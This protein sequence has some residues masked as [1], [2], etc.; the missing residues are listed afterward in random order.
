M[1]APKRLIAASVPILAAALA[2][3]TGGTV[4]RFAPCASTDT[5]PQSTVCEAVATGVPTF[6]TWSCGG[7][8]S[9][10][11]C[12]ND[13]NGIQG[14]CVIAIGNDDTTIGSEDSF[15]FCLQ[16]CSSGGAC[17]DGETCQPAQDY[18]GGSESDMV[19]VPSQ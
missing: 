8:T 2:C 18:T 7:E 19:C 4:A 17:P 12:P 13:A 14:V 5:C 3:G 10:Q 1:T 6:C 11:S 15:G 9:S 16:D